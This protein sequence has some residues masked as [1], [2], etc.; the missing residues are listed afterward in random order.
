MHNNNSR[1]WYVYTTCKVILHYI[2]YL[3]KLQHA[4]LYVILHHTRFSAQNFNGR[5]DR[6][7]TLETVPVLGVMRQLHTTAH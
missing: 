2:H 3:I 1:L 7:P 5:L 6:H 4:I